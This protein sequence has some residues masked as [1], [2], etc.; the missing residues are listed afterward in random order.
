M[1]ALS[2]LE[3]TIPVRQAFL[4]HHGNSGVGCVYG[5]AW[6]VGTCHILEFDRVI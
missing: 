2:F 6:L 1:V 3:I 4:G 5:R